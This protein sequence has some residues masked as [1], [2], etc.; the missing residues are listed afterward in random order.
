[1]PDGARVLT[2]WE[3]RGLYCLPKCYP[4]EVLDRWVIAIRELQD[5]SL[6]LQSWENAGYTHIL[7]YKLGAEFIREDD[8]R[9]RTSDWKALHEFLARLPPPTDI[10]GVYELYSLAP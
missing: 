6:V 4:D 10:G 1:L 8:A 5:P 7:Y 2:L 3:P 9:Y